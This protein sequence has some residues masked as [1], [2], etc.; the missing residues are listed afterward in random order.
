MKG[1]ILS[2]GEDEWHSSVGRLSLERALPVRN[3]EKRTLKWEEEEG[4]GRK[5]SK[6]LSV[7]HPVLV[8]LPASN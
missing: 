4:G 6:L 3:E 5:R 8:S 7:C 1:S 2:S